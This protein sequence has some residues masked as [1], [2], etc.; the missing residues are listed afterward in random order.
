MTSATNRLA[1]NLPVTVEASA[2]ECTLTVT[3]PSEQVGEWWQIY[4]RRWAPEGYGTRVVSD[5]TNDL[6]V[7]VMKTDRARSC[8]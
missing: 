8:D 1:F 6:G 7:R 5:V 2:D 3:G 4:R